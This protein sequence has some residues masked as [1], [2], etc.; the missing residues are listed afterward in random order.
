MS[1][2]RLAFFFILEIYSLVTAQ[3]AGGSVAFRLGMRTAATCPPY[4]G[5]P[6]AG[7]YVRR[8]S[9]CINKIYLY[10]LLKFSTSI[11]NS[12]VC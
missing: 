5:N 7:S 4:I 6:S 9:L 1:E 2:T 12:I 8:F 3:R 10:Y 11:L